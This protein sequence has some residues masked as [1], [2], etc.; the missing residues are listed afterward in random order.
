MSADDI[1]SATARQVST[2]AH[3]VGHHLDY[4]AGPARFQKRSSAYVADVQDFVTAR[5]A[6]AKDLVAKSLQPSVKMSKAKAAAVERLQGLYKADTAL[7]EG[8]AARHMTTLRERYSALGLDLKQ[9]EGALAKHTVIGEHDLGGAAYR[10]RLGQLATAIEERDARA[11]LNILED[12]DPSGIGRRGGKTYDKGLEGHLSDL[13]GSATNNKI[14]GSGGHSTSYLKNPGAKEAECFANLCAMFADGNPFWR[15]IVE[16][17]T[18]RMTKLFKE[19]L[20]A[21]Q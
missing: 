2:W 20:D 17:F 1:E 13:F 4:T 10:K 16:R 3:E 21:D 11:F 19:I 12:G 6:D 18:P 9:V 14:I 15:V 7:A 5:A 8:P